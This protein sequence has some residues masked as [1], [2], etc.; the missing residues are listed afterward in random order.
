MRRFLVVFSIL[1]ISFC[2]AGP[3]PASPG[4]H[5][6]SGLIRIPTAYTLSKGEVDA[7][8]DMYW[9]RRAGNLADVRFI[10]SRLVTGLLDESD[11]GV[12]LGLHRVD[13]SDAPGSATAITGKYRFPGTLQLGAVALGGRVSVAG[14]AQNTIYVVGS[15]NA[16]KV[17]AV[18]YGLGLNF[19]NAQGLFSLSG[20][21]DRDLQSDRLYAMFGAEMDLWDTFKIN[22]DFN[23]DTVAYGV[24]WYP[25]DS[26]VVSV[27]WIG[28]GEMERAYD[29]HNGLG[30]GVTAQF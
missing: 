26:L 15:T 24:N 17:F 23:G 13:I 11:Y 12:E 27:F 28:A 22:A 7:A 6:G 5:G 29:G 8:V 21:K 18:H 3:L 30:L 16:A 1:A 19:S 4:L 10:N 14:P 25:V 20:G 9:L 2:C